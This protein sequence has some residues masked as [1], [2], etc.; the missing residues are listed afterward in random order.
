MRWLFFIIA[1]LMVVIVL[2]IMQRFT[3]LEFVAHARLLFKTWS[4]WL[5]SLGSMLSA[6]VQSFPAASVDAWNTLPEDVKSILPHNYLGLIG[7]FM[8]AMGVI[9]QF[10]RQKNLVQQKQQLEAKKS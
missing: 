1:V 2:L 10:V 8:V 3:T 7:A 4:V 9:A 5:A 6:W